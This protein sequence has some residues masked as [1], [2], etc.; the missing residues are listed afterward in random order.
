MADKK[1]HG[2]IRTAGLRLGIWIPDFEGT[3][4]KG[5]YEH[6]VDFLVLPPQ[7]KKANNQNT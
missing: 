4:Q 5:E 7:N 3:N 6:S 2:K 1:N